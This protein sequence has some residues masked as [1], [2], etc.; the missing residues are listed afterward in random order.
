M[1][2]TSLDMAITAVARDLTRLDPSPDFRARVLEALPAARPRRWLPLALAA[3]AAGAAAALVAA[4]LPAASLLDDAPVPVTTTGAIGI[5]SPH[6]IES[7]RV[8]SDVTLAAGEPALSPE[9]L[10]WRARAVPTLPPIDLLDVP[11]IQPE[12]VGIAPISVD[13]IQSDAIAIEPLERSA[14]RE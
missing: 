11:A 8:V 1:T 10:A 14:G 13:P 12:D 6:I 7:P 3:G 4:L 9:E 2:T 5:P